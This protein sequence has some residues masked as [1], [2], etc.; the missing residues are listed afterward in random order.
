MKGGEDQHQT[1]NHKFNSQPP[2]PQITHTKVQNKTKNAQQQSKITLHK[3]HK[4][5][6]LNQVQTKPNK[7]QTH[8]KFKPKQSANNTKNFKPN[9]V[10]TTTS[11]QKIISLPKLQTTHT[12]K[13]QTKQNANKNQ[14][15]HNSSQTNHSKNQIHNQATK[16]KCMRER[17]LKIERK[18]LINV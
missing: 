13:V 9:K 2:K 12:H 18:K 8:K 3:Q 6:H 5:S 16:T 17:T 11:P 10:Q 14:N 4:S 1:T 7:V 15:A